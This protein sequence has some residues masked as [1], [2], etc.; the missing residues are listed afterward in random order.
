MAKAAL[1][2]LQFYLLFLLV[3]IIVKFAKSIL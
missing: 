1:L 3:L 2:F